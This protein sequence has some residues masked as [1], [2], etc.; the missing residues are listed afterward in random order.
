MNNYFFDKNVTS[1]SKYNYINNDIT[2]GIASLEYADDTIT[3]SPNTYRSDYNF[4]ASK[5][6]VFPKITKVIF[7]PGVKTE[8][9]KVL[10]KGATIVYFS[11]RTKTVVRKSSEDDNNL[12]MALIHAIIKRIY[13]KV[14][15]KTG[16]VT[17]GTGNMIQRLLNNAVYEDV[18]IVPDKNTDSNKNHNDEKVKPFLGSCS[19]CSDLGSCV[20]E[21][22]DK[23]IKIFKMGNLEISMN[24]KDGSLIIKNKNGNNNDTINSKSDGSKKQ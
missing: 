9:G 8:S 7:N 13:G 18:K 19:S 20:P 15:E 24:S 2:T 14:D 6:I 17:G 10:E 3:I 12:E 23:L 11:D 1:T 4:N 16:F 22:S 5:D 21:E